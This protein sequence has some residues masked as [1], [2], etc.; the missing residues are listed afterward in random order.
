MLFRS[1]NAI[2]RLAFDGLS[3]TAANSKN[4]AEIRATDTTLAAIARFKPKDC[5]CNCGG[6]EAAPEVVRDTVTISPNHSLHIK[7]TP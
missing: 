6:Q 2:S 3:V 1:N 7:D 5:D 4:A